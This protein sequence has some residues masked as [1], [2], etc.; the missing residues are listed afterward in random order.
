MNKNKMENKPAGATLLK[1][2]EGLTKCNMK[3]ANKNISLS[4]FKFPPCEYIFG[5]S[6][7]IPKGHPFKFQHRTWVG[8]IHKKLVSIWGKHHFFALRV[9]QNP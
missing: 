4:G 8:F 3:R 2:R 6:H 7:R 9:C 5:L 1:N